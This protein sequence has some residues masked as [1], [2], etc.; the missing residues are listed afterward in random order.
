MTQPAK[1]PDPAGKTEDVLEADIERLLTE[2]AALKELIGAPAGPRQ[3]QQWQ[4]TLERW[5]EG[6]GEDQELARAI[7]Q[8][9]RRAKGA[10]GRDPAA[11]HDIGRC[12]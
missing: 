5:A 9:P 7:G 11:G 3:Q 10:S 4:A 2:N 6:A 8:A 1:R 12:D